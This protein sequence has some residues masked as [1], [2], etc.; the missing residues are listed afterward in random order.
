MLPK[1]SRDFHCIE[2]SV[3]VRVPGAQEMPDSQT[4]RFFLFIACRD[5]TQL[6]TAQKLQLLKVGK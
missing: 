3:F 6:Q 1:K 4:W 5:I 2:A